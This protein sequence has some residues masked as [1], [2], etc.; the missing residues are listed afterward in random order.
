[1]A[2]I[3]SPPHTPLLHWEE[4][5]AFSWEEGPLQQ[6]QSSL[7]LCD[8]AVK[9]ESPTLSPDAFAPSHHL[10]SPRQRKPQSGAASPAAVAR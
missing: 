7:Q 4:Q 3:T 8:T 1:M 2:Y 6:Q 10:L 9:E 5:P